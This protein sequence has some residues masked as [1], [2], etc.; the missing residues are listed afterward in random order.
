MSRDRRDTEFGLLRQHYGD[1][2][3]G[4]DFEWAVVRAVPL[5]NGWNRPATEVLIVV[6]PGYPLTPPD[7]FFVRNG[8][9]L[10]DGSLPANFAEN[11]SVL[12]DSWAQ[13]SFHA[14][15]WNPAP[16]PMDGDNLMTFMLAVEGRLR[17]LS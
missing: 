2:H 15:S 6:P 14:Q 1:V 13:F 12:G 16:E 17:E 11:Q 8:L 10:A 9:R 3:A 5:C 4:S 7:N